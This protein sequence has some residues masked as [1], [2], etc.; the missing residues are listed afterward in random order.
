MQTRRVAA[1][2]LL[3]LSGAALGFATARTASGLQPA[4]A[5]TAASTGALAP[6]TY[7][8]DNVH[9]SV[10]FRIQHVG[11]GR[12]YGRFNELRGTFAFDPESGELSSI[13]MSIPVDS[14]DTNN[15]QRDE[16][17]ESPDFFDAAQFP[18][19]SFRS[20][21]IEKDDDEYEVKGE[22][23]L[24]G[25]T[26]PIEVELEWLGTA[27]VRGNEVAGFEAKFRI[28]RTRWGMTKYTE[29][30]IG[31]EVDLIVSVEAVRQK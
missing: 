10:V 7:E 21:S 22:L 24:H 14:V 8:V 26:H 15:V 30:A 12:F 16:H 27:E 18:T 25:Q 17:L 28:D 29:G 23:T 3:A 19:I 1:I 13:D 6:A 9:S 5:L 20:T 31:R 2:A 11:V 4:A